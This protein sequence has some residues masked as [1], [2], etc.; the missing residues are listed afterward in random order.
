TEVVVP[1]LSCIRRGEEIDAP[2][3]GDREHGPL[4]LGREERDVVPAESIGVVAAQVLASTQPREVVEGNLM[5]RVSRRLE[6]C[7]R[8][9]EERG[10]QASKRNVGPR[11]ELLLKPGVG[12]QCVVTADV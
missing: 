2:D 9:Q 8:S 7:A 5:L 12:D 10:S 4:Q 11:V 1:D 6:L 3:T